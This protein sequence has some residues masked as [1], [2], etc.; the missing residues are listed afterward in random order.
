MVFLI[1]RN[2]S[3]ENDLP[4]ENDWV[5]SIQIATPHLYARVVQSFLTMENGE[6]PLEHFMFLENDKQL[7]SGKLLIV[8]SDPF[9]IDF[10]SKKIAT[11]LYGEINK[12]ILSDPLRHMAWE[13]QVIALSELIRETSREIPI[14]IDTQNEITMQDACKAL[15]VRIDCPPDTSPQVRVYKLMDIIA[16]WM[17]KKVLVLCNLDSYFSETD[18]QEII[19]Y[20]CYTKVKLLIVMHSAEIALHEQEIRVNSQSKCHSGKGVAVTM[21]NGCS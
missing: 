14:E 7:D 18:W 3:F 20:A 13:K 4:F 16:E 21:K 15:G 2:I 19:K 5:S 1:L 11:A 6:E 12:L 9:R 10:A 17:P 8:V